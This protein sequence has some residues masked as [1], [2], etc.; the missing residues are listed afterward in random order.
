VTK[1]YG[2][3]LLVDDLSFKVPAGAIVA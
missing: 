1:C 3:R 2:D